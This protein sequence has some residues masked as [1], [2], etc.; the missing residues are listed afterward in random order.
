MNFV[1]SSVPRSPGFAFAPPV[2][3]RAGAV[4]LAL[5]LAVAASPLPLRAVETYAKVVSGVAGDGLR[6]EV[7][8]QQAETDPEGNV[9]V[10]GSLHGPAQF[11]P[12][13]ALAR[14]GTTQANEPYDA[15]LGLVGTNGG[16]S[17][18]KRIYVPLIGQW[19]SRATPRRELTITSVRIGTANV[20]VTGTFPPEAG[21][22]AGFVTKLTKSGDVVWTRYVLGGP[23]TSAAVTSVVE[24]A[25]GVVYLGGRFSGNLESVA[26]LGNQIVLHALGNT[27][28][29]SDLAAFV[30]KTEASGAYTWVNTTTSSIGHTEEVVAMEI[31]GAGDV[32]VLMN[33]RDNNASSIDIR[34]AGG[35]NFQTNVDL[36]YTAAP[37][38][39]KLGANGVWKQGRALGP[40]DLAASAWTGGQYSSEV[41][42]NDLRLVGGKAFV[43]GAASHIPR[44]AAR[45][46][47][48]F[49]TRLSAVDY[50][51][52]GA[53]AHFWSGDGDKDKAADPVRMRAAGRT[54]FVTGNMPQTL[55][56]YGE[57]PPTAGTGGAA[58]LELTSLSQSYCVGA[59]DTNLKP[60]WM[61]T[62]S[63]SD[64][65]PIPSGTTAGLLAVDGASQRVYWG[66]QFRTGSD[67]K[68][69]LGDV[70]A[71]I[72]LGTFR[73]SAPRED[74]DAWGWIT[75]F[76]LD[77]RPV[78]QVR[79]VVDSAFPPIVV[80]G[81]LNS[82]NRYE[83]NLFEGAPVQV[84]VDDQESDGTRNTV[85]GFTL[86]NQQGT[87][88]AKSLAINLLTDTKVTF[89]W[90][91]Q[92]RLRIKSEHAESGLS[93]LTSA[94]NPEPLI[95]DSW[96]DD[97]ALVDSTIDGWV[98]PVSGGAWGT[99]Y[100][101]SGYD[102]VSG[103]FSTSRTIPPADLRVRVAELKD[104]PMT[105]PV[106]ITYRWKKQHRINVQTSNPE[107]TAM[108]LVRQTT[109]PAAFL[110][111][112]GEQW[113]D[114]NAAV[115]ILARAANATATLILQ[116]WDFAEPVP[117]IFPLSTFTVSPTSVSLR[118]ELVGNG[119][120]SSV[121]ISNVTYFG[122]TVPKLTQP[123]TV[124]W[125]FGD[126]IQSTNIAVGVPFKFPAL[127]GRTPST[128]GWSGPVQVLDGPP[129]SIGDD[130][131]VWDPRNQTVIPTRPGI[132]QVQVPYSNA[133]GTDLV[134]WQ[135]YSGFHGEVWRSHPGGPNRYSNP[136]GAQRHIAST[137]AVDLDPSP[138][139]RFFFKGL[140]YSSVNAT[141]ADGRFLSSAPGYSVLLYSVLPANAS[142]RAVDDR[143][144]EDLFVRVVETVNWDATGILRTDATAV[145]I[146]TPLASTDDVAQRGTGYV[147][148]ENAN[149]NPDIYDRASASGPIIPVNS[150]ATAPNLASGRELVVVWYE[151]DLGAQWPARP[152]FYPSFA[153][154]SVQA[155]RIVIA[156]RL[157]S[158]GLDGAGQ[159]QTRFEPELYEDVRIYHQPDPD[160]AGHNPNEEHARIYPSM[161]AL[162]GGRSVPAAF[163]LRN[164]LN[165]TANLIARSNGAL[166]NDQ[167][168][169][170]PFVLVQ[171]R[172]KRTGKAGMAI[173]AV[174]RDD[175]NTQDSWVAELPG[176]AGRAYTFSYTMLAGERITA[177]YPLNQVLGLAPCINNVPNPLTNANTPPNGTFFEPGANSAHAWFVDHKNGTWASAGDAL[178]R[179]Y[180]LYPLAS[181]FWYPPSPSMPRPFQPPKSA[182]ASPG[183]RP[184][185][186]PAASSGSSIV[187]PRTST[188][189]ASR[190]K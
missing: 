183:S 175:P 79:L 169:S 161:H 66:G 97:Q 154:P 51:A 80:N 136:A 176:S 148:H 189:G 56:V 126:P 130:M 32:H 109:A 27:P 180:F 86:D 76:G 45:L 36:P 12:G 143:S 5:I 127:A 87:T 155:N 6:D 17:W 96:I 83:E 150:R 7:T 181:D 62:T 23:N 139:D 65:V 178:I 146:G 37:W 104:T 100:V 111:G 157:G 119:G 108:P 185:I 187:I 9:Y 39:G 125:N 26:V 93:D 24:G 35:A 164:D 190:P 94:G 184:S 70:P 133:T 53:V 25:G 106:T 28:D 41:R 31:D 134:V 72:A 177:P 142:G 73:T 98:Q 95:G 10:A 2:R 60:L 46:R 19:A 11:A 121:V 42:A 129:G 182:T 85:T 151:S 172:E 158:E 30:M 16:W 152:V 77:G 55:E 186:P 145:P 82:T 137:P 14:T 92:H 166:R 167:Y 102:F 173:Y 123:A 78:R 91:T 64:V 54:L 163:A 90:K 103:T 118:D 114:D 49:I 116:G 122:A 33:L 47:H 120:L 128:A 22:S 170:D 188:P 156:S 75:A 74:V 40:N 171:Y 88:P 15:F 48:G 147:V 159:R 58:D 1:Q 162:L 110:P 71:E 179:A 174:Q 138:D 115:E 168:T 144:R 68:L 81:V 107:A 43:C 69:L 165:I 105:Q 4:W 50:L 34:H 99:R 18:A 29:P 59:F 63:R 135:I 124:V 67:R 61:R 20:Y 140:R 84:S 160:K 113:C 112:T 101:V 149:Y 44:G 57:I 21:G 8:L 52:D 3:R 38:V 117:A 13:I 153:W 89:S 141:S 131:L 132:S